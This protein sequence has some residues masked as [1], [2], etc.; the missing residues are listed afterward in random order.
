MKATT[1]GANPPRDT[2][3][4]AIGGLVS[5]SQIDAQKRNKATTIAN[6]TRDGIAQ[7]IKTAFGKAH[8]NQGEFYL[9]EIAKHI[10]NKN[11]LERVLGVTMPSWN[12]STTIKSIS[13]TA[14]KYGN[15][16]ATV[17]INTP[18]ANPF[19]KAIRIP[20]KGLSDAEVDRIKIKRKI[21]S[22]LANARIRNQGN[23]KLSEIAN[24]INNGKDTLNTLKQLG[25]ALPTFSELNTNKLRLSRPHAS[26]RG[27]KLHIELVLT[28]PVKGKSS[29]TDTFEQDI[30]G[31]KSDSQIDAQNKNALRDKNVRAIEGIL[32]GIKLQERK[33]V[34]AAEIAKSFNATPKD[35]KIWALKYLTGKD[36]TQ[37]HKG[38]DITDITLVAD[39][40]G[41]IKV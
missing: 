8:I 32:A 14:D 20:A 25:I 21:E 34:I 5:D 23:E 2:I 26:V 1:P 35:Q 18:G 22:T 29:I 4:H 39:S 11:S 6:Q 10:T 41:N 24:K 28:T 7:M 16:I 9:S 38:T 30:P 33:K 3:R 40:Q 36:L 12:G 19:T 37:G 15:L 31:G 27:G 13:A 17:V